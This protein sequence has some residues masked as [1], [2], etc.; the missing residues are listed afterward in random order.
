MVTQ[1]DIELYL[2]LEHEVIH[3]KLEVFPGINEDQAMQF[4]ERVSEAQ[5]LAKRQFKELDDKKKQGGK[6][7][8][9]ADSD[10]DAKDSEAVVGGFKNKKMVAG[11]G[12]S[13][14]SL[15]KRTK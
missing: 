3:K 15:K 5:V 6:K 12:G 9:H 1:Y 4:M 11:A 8:G 10:D 14:K 13:G 2:R 7:R